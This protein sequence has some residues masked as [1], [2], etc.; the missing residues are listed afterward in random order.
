MPQQ[1]KERFKKSLCDI[2]AQS[3]LNI[4]K[5]MESISY[6]EYIL[7]I[8]N[9]FLTTSIVFITVLSTINISKGLYKTDLIIT[10]VSS[11]LLIAQLI[12]ISSDIRNTLEKHKFSYKN[13]IFIHNYTEKILLNSHNIE[14]LMIILDIINDMYRYILSNSTSIPY[15][16]DKKYK[17]V[18]LSLETMSPSESPDEKIELITRNIIENKV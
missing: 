14:E 16:I 4:K 12:Y 2:K 15:L 8:H 7:W 13:Y 10:S 9:M 18:V 5:H 3:Q 11:I 6:Y 17:Y 1:Q